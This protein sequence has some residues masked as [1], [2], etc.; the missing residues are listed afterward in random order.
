LYRSEKIHRAW[1]LADKYRAKTALKRHMFASDA[2]TCDDPRGIYFRIQPG[3]GLKR[4]QGAVTAPLDGI[5]ALVAMRQ[6]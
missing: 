2:I 4:F 5:A 6:P 1:K 3:A